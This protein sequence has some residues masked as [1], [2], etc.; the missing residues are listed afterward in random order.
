M[1]SLE[2]KPDALSLEYIWNALW[3]EQKS[4]T[5]LPQQKPEE[6]MTQDVSDALLLQYK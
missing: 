5:M 2:Y 3:F 1:L 6:I 4:Y